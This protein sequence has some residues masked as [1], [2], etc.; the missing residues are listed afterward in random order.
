MNPIATYN[1]V[2]GIEVS[3]IIDGHRKTV[4]YYGFTKAEAIALFKEANA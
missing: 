2:G 3:D 4:T 1:P